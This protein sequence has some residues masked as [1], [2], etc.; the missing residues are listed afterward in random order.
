MAISSKVLIP[1]LLDSSREVKPGISIKGPVYWPVPSISLLG[2]LKF[3]VATFDIVATS[4]FLVIETR[5]ILAH[6]SKFVN[7]M[8][9]LRDALTAWGKPLKDSCPTYSMVATFSGAC[10]TLL[11]H[12]Q[13]ALEDNDHT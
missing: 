12:W 13:P 10:Y 1:S 11:A 8:I 6:R 3:E 5:E 2:S 4:P 7:T 9:P